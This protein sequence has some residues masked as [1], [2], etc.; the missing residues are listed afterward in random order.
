MTAWNG[1]RLITVI[2]ACMSASGLPDF[3]LNE[4]EVT[5]DDYEN[6]VHYDYVV[7][8][9]VDAGYEEPFVHFDEID[10]PAFLVPAVKEYLGRDATEPIT[11]TSSEGS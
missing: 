7:D 4:V 9:L 6:G 10:S 8:K 2:S 1:K 5:H 3:A 11:V